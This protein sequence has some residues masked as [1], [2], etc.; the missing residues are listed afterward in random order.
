[1]LGECLIEPERE[2]S[3]GQ[4]DFRPWMFSA[5]KSRDPDIE[6]VH[7]EFPIESDCRIYWFQRD[8]GVGA[9]RLNSRQ[10]PNSKFVLPI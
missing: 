4:R 9:S 1:V 7:G 6:V 8:F 2:L 10:F 3:K 5:T